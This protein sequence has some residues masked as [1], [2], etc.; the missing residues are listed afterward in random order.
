MEWC[1][2]H[3]DQPAADDAGEVHGWYA[4]ER[5]YKDTD[6]GDDGFQDFRAAVAEAIKQGLVSPRIDPDDPEQL[7]V[8][9]ANM[10]Y[11]HNTDE[12]RAKHILT[13]LVDM[14]GG[15]R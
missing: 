2:C 10:P 15:E 1:K 5:A 8:V 13:A 9:K 14:N 6:P 7:R 3:E 11:W 12:K 4:V